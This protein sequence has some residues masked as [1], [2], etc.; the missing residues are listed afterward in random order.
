MQWLL[1]R[2]IANSTWFHISNQLGKRISFWHQDKH[3]ASRMCV[4]PNALEINRLIFVLQSKVPFKE[5]LDFLND[6]LLLF[7][8]I[9]PTKP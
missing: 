5:G 8:S 4:S 3:N 9:A 2:F 6:S 1:Y 7:L